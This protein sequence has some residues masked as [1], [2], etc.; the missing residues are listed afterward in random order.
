MSNKK[1]K[2]ESS[3]ADLLKPKKKYVYT[4]N[5]ILC[6]GIEVDPRTQEKHARDKIL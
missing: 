3:V 2:I 6:K 5:C 1:C 4:C